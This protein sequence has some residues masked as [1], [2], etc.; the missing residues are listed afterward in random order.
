MFKHRHLRRAERHRYFAGLL[1][2]GAAF[3]GLGAEIA[4]M[5]TAGPF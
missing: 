2:A 4:W 5:V 3:V 1:I